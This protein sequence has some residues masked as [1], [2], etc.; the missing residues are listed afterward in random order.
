[1]IY[2]YLQNLFIT[3]NFDNWIRWLD[4]PNSLLNKKKTKSNKKHRQPSSQ[5]QTQIII[6]FKM[7]RWNTKLWSFSTQ[8][9]NTNVFPSFAHSFPTCLPSF[10]VC[11]IITL[12]TCI[13][14]ALSTFSLLFSLPLSL[15]LSLTYTHTHTP[16]FNKRR[17]SI[18]EWILL[19]MIKVHSVSFTL[20][21][22]KTKAI[23]NNY[24]L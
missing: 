6:W 12:S 1:M 8:E 13:W 4:Q 19:L 14:C 15:S 3:L 20:R 11:L 2:L 5:S 10:Y 9:C 7:R 17:D 21:S 23:D 24:L 18:K 22:Q 16:H